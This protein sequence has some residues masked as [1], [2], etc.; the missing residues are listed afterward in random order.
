[1]LAA[2]SLPDAARIPVGEVALAHAL[3]SYPCLLISFLIFVL[4]V[5]YEL[6]LERSGES[7]HPPA[8]ALCI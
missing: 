1:V 3:V 2:A 8:P 4:V 5:A 6:D 7:Y